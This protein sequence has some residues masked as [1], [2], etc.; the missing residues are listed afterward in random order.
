MT[1]PKATVHTRARL[2]VAALLG[3]LLAALVASAAPAA[4]GRGIERDFAVREGGVLR[5]DTEGARIAVRGTGGDRVIVQLARGNDTAAELDED[6]E[7]EMTQQGNDVSV[8]I[9]PRRSLGWIHFGWRR[10]AL[11]LDARVPHRY[12]VDLTTSG[13]SIGVAELKG[14]VRTRTSGGSLDFEAIDGTVLGRTSGGSI[15]I[16][17]THGNADV[18]TSGG[19]IQIGTVSG[20]VRAH[21]SGGSIEIER[22]GASVEATTSGGS[23][24]I[25]EVAGPVSA[26]T[27]GGG[28]RAYLSKQPDADCRLSTSGGSV[29]V[30]LEAGLA[31]DID[32]SS[33]GGKVT[34]DLPLLATA[35]SDSRLRGVLNAGGPLL[36]LRSSGGGIRIYAK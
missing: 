36:H 10:E 12:D 5:V 2:P 19:G 25:E 23:I 15:Y 22:A 35:S 27:S 28:I 34:T 29:I 8:V 14:D 32:A 9:K 20:T 6:F 1:K 30:Y 3:A 7:V 17:D 4:P 21:T 11:E 24:D 31:L 18:E 16:R 26:S 13:G 33:S